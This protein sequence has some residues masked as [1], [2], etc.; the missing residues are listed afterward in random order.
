MVPKDLAQNLKFR[1]HISDRAKKDS[2][3]RSSIKAM[4]KQDVLFFI[5]TFLW[6]FDPR[7]SNTKVVP[8]ITWEFQDKFIEEKIDKCYGTENLYIEKS[9][10]MGASWCVL[11][12]FAWKFLFYDHETLGL[13]SRDLD[14]VDKKD[15]PS[16]LFWKVDFIIENLPGYLKPVIR[17]Q[18]ER[19][20]CKLVN[21][22]NSSVITGEATKG[23]QPYRGGRLTAVLFDEVSACEPSD[24]TRSVATLPRSTNCTIFLST[25]Q[26]N[27]DEY[28]RL[29]KK[30]KEIAVL[31][32]KDH[33][34]KRRGLYKGKDG[35][36]EYKDPIYVYPADYE[37]CMDG[38]WRSVE[39]DYDEF[40]QGLTPTQMAQEW[41]H[42]YVGSGSN[43]FDLQVLEKQKN[44]YCRQPTWTGEVEKNRLKLKNSYLVST[45]HGSLKIWSL[46]VASNGQIQTRK[47]SFVIGCDIAVGT[48]ATPSVAAIIDKSSG[49]KVAQYET[50]RQNP[51]EF[52]YTVAALG[53]IFNNAKIIWETNGPGAKFGQTLI[54]DIKYHN[55]YYQRDEGKITKKRTQRAGWTSSN[56]NSGSTKVKLLGR[57]NHYLTIG[58]YCEPDENTIDECAEY[59][60]KGSTVVHPRSMNQDDDADAR[61]NHGDHAIATALAVW[62]YFENPAPKGPDNDPSY[63]AVTLAMFH[64]QYRKKELYETRGF[65]RHCP[66]PDYEEQEA[67]RL[68]KE[69]YG[70]R[71]RGI[72]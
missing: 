5:N 31:D 52:A 28:A 62:D 68:R 14:S 58:K 7:L 42:A 3:F 22:D 18:K 70:R 48:G 32:W 56:G 43:F 25:P 47:K 8:F 9:R 40:V 15:D 50:S 17:N 11:A 23:G 21:P 39:Y 61:E 33:P 45:K 20:S 72:W 12:Y 69:E 38:K 64:E 26:G 29:R 16:S 2:E 36:F 35:V 24:Q 71:D 27:S 4:C 65:D 34:R 57:L 67:L 6:T 13:L 19:T 59:V 49:Q 46:P 66:G 60:Y 55:I 44:T 30:I 37:F 63:G 51:D 10:D 54:E 1:K 41:D 53:H